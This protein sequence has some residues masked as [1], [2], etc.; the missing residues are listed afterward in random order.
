MYKRIKSWPNNKDSAEAKATKKMAVS[1]AF[2]QYLATTGP[3]KDFHNERASFEASRV[4]FQ[5]GQQ[6][7]DFTLILYD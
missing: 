2:F 4:T 5:V 1:K 6:I 3:F 7:S